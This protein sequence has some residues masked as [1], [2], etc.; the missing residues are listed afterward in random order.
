MV[1][2]CQRSAQKYLGARPTVSGSDVV[3]RPRTGASN[4]PIIINIVAAIAS[5][6]DS[7]DCS[8]GLGTAR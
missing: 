7:A 3:N 2:Q 4:E 6:K 5:F 1:A 8:M